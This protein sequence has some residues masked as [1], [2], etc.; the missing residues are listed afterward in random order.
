MSKSEG[1]DYRLENEVPEIDWKKLSERDAA[2]FGL[3]LG[4]YRELTH[5]EELR[6]CAFMTSVG[7]VIGIVAISIACMFAGIDVYAAMI[8]LFAQFLRSI[9][10]YLKA[11]KWRTWIV[12][13]EDGTLDFA[14]ELAKR[15]PVNDGNQQSHCC[16]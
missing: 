16:G 13:L 2:E 6:R 7:G 12:D 15:H 4:K 11:R 1:L 14:R 8:I 5:D 3:L 10:L 9:R